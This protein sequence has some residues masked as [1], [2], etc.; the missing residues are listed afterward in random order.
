[1][2]QETVRPSLFPVQ[3]A[4]LP[5]YA[6]SRGFEQPWTWQHQVLCIETAV[7][8]QGRAQSIW[9]VSARARSLLD[10]GR[11]HRGVPELVW[12]ETRYY[13]PPAA[14]SVVRGRGSAFT[15]YP[16]HQPRNEPQAPYLARRNV[17]YFVFHF[18]AAA[19]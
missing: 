10:R 11:N 12:V 9:L 18:S 17:R 4:A 8:Y 3:D 15:G 16:T 13:F 6:S 14:Q 7:R 2:E 1:V 19:S 5:R